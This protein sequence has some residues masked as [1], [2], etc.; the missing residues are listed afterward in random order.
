MY[1]YIYLFKFDKLY[2]YC[3]IES[4]SVLSRM[5]NLKPFYYLIL[6]IL[7]KY[8]KSHRKDDGGNQKRIQPEPP[9]DGA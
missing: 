3:R 6:E 9:V 1:D 2:V 4:E 8:S 5:L 7:L